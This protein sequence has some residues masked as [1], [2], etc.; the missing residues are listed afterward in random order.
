M[1]STDGL[2]WG[3]SFK[4]KSILYFFLKNFLPS[5]AAQPDSPGGRYSKC[6][7]YPREIRTYGHSD[8]VQHKG[9]SPKKKKNVLKPINCE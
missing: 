8:Y 3:N 7:D 5:A 2:Q 4:G 1:D 6:K 9:T